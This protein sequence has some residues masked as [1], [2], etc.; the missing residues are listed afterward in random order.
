MLRVAGV[1]CTLGMATPAQAVDPLYQP[2]M[3]NLLFA[4]GSLYFLQPLCGA[5]GFDWRQKAADLI[6]ADQPEDDRRLRLTGS[7]NDGYAAYNRLYRDCTDSA[8]LAIHQILIE[9]EELTRDIHTR[10]AE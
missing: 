6:E 4:M 1:V 7:F 5:E 10:Y 9:A 3:Q 2:Q 8:Q